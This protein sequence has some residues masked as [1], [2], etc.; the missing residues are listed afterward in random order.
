MLRAATPAHVTETRLVLF[1][2]A[3]HATAQRVLAEG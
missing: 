2:A 3:T 1:G